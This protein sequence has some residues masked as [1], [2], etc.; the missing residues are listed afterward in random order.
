MGLPGFVTVPPSAAGDQFAVAVYNA[1]ITGIA[2]TT[3][4]NMF[5]PPTD[6]SYALFLS[7]SQTVLGVGSPGATTFTPTVGFTDPSG[8]SGSTIA[9]GAFTTGSTNGTLG[10]IAL[11]SGLGYVVFRAKAGV[12]ITILVTVTGGG[13]TT[14][15]TVAIYPVL[16]SLGA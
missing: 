6:G 13:G 16:V 2:T 10:Y 4:K 8:A 7:A 5:T 11:A 15:P 12:S 3:A 1:P 14:N 9:M